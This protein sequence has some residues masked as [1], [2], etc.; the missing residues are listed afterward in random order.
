MQFEHIF[1]TLVRLSYWVFCTPH[2]LAIIYVFNTNNIIHSN[3]NLLN[4]SAIVYYD[5]AHQLIVIMR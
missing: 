2:L 4:F 5:G 3:S 1:S